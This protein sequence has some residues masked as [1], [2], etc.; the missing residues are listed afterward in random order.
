MSELFP[1]PLL[2]SNG[3][4]QV[5]KYRR[6][7]GRTEGLLVTFPGNHYGVDGPL[8]YYPRSHFEAV[9]WDTF[10]LTYGYQSGGK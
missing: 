9:G 7:A 5:H 1:L 4:P 6:Q 8:L 10:G 3:E 2:T